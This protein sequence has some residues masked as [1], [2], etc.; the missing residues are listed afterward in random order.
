MHLSQSKASYEA[1]GMK[2]GISYEAPYEV[3]SQGIPQGNFSYDIVISLHE[4]N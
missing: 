2:N 3:H 4:F 1:R